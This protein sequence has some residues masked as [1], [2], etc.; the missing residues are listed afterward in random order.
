MPE[1]KNSHDW[2]VTKTYGYATFYECTVCLK[3]KCYS[4]TPGWP[5]SD[6]F[7]TK[8]GDEISVAPYA[9]PP[10]TSFPETGLFSD[11]NNTTQETK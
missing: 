7:Y 8:Q 4:W 11:L 5:G 2:Q 9:E 6:S 10:C 1:A 3:T